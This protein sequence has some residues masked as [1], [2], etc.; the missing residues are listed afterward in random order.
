MVILLLFVSYAVFGKFIPKNEED[1]Q[2][3]TPFTI[4]TVPIEVQ[5]SGKAY[6]IC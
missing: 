5:V 4:A 6:P 1:P 3:V 2:H